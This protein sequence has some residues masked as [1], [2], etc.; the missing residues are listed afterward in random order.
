VNN[1]IPKNL[2]KY[3]TLNE[4]TFSLLNGEIFFSPH[5]LLNDP[6]DLNPSVGLKT[7]FQA[8]IS[9]LDD[10]ITRQLI[11]K[12]KEDTDPERIAK[13]N[14]DEW[15][16][17]ISQEMFEEEYLSREEEIKRW[18]EA[19]IKMNQITMRAK[20]M[21]VFCLTTRRDDYSMWAHY[22]DGLRGIVIGFDTEKLVTAFKELKLNVHGPIKVQYKPITFRKLL[23]SKFF[24]K[25]ENLFTFKPPVWSSEREIRFVWRDGSGP[26]KVPISCISEI[27]IGRRA[28]LSWR[29]RLKKWLALQD[30]NWL[31]DTSPEYPDIKF[32]IASTNSWGKVHML[33]SN[34]NYGLTDRI[35]ARPLT[36]E[37]QALID[38]V[39][40]FENP[41]LS[42]DPTDAPEKT[43]PAGLSEG[44]DVPF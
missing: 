29:R 14:L 11:D 6:T 16:I 5:E 3:R 1:E 34:K 9:I 32:L 27:I 35:C 42:I 24:S 26:I 28:R 12:Y 38:D 41:I 23:K 4:W 19:W 33:K 31:V 22:A 2:Y 25:P 43:D 21:G 30:D 7:E 10:L 8:Q 44:D 40:D 20:R 39:E 18:E 17:D 37:E 13:K 15:D 36:L